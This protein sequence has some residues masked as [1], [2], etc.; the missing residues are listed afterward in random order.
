MRHARFITAAIGLLTLFFCPLN[1]AKSQEGPPPPAP[2]PEAPLVVDETGMVSMNFENLDVR[3]L[4]KYIS[5]LTGKNFIVDESVRGPITIVSPTKIPI[6]EAYKVF[7]SILEVKGFAAIPAGKVMKVAAKG[8]QATRNIDLKVGGDLSQIVPEDTLVTQLIPLQYVS[9]EK[10]NTALARLFSRE[11]AVIPYPTTNTL[12][13]TDYSSNIHRLVKIIKELDVP[14]YETRITVVPL[15]Y[16]AADSLATELSQVIEQA[17]VLPGGPP[18]PA[19]RGRPQTQTSEK[20]IKIIPDERTNSVIILANDDDTRKVLDLIKR[21]DVETERT[22]IHVYFLKNSNAEEMGKVMNN[23]VSK[24]KPK[25][26]EAVPLISEDK[27]TNALLIDATPEDYASLEKIIQK[28]DVLRNQVLVE[29]LIAEVGYDKTFELGVEWRSL[30]GFPDTA[31]M[32]AGR[33]NAEGFGEMLFG[34]G[35][36]NY[37]TAG[38]NP[39]SGLTGV[40]LG[41]VQKMAGAGTSIPDFGILV[42]ALQTAQGVNIL[43]TPQILTTDNQEATIKVVKNIPYVTKF[44]TGTGDQNPVQN[45]EY[46]DVGITLKIT[47]HVSK[48]GVVRMEVDTEISDVTGKQVSGLYSTPETY[49]RATKT[50][51]IVGD[52]HTIVLGGLVRDDKS[53]TEDKVPI[54]GDIPLL[55]LLFRTTSTVSKKTN[56][57]IFITPRVVHTTQQIA[58]LTKLKRHEMSD[59]DQRMSEEEEEKAVGEYEMRE[60]EHAEIRDLKARYGS[61]VPA[62]SP[63]AAVEPGPES[64]AP[65]AAREDAEGSSASAPAATIT[66]AP[67]SDPAIATS[68]ASPVVAASP[69]SP[70]AAPA[71]SPPEAKKESSL[72]DMLPRV[73]FQK[74]DKD[75]ADKRKAAQRFHQ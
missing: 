48:E 44:E 57:L 63:A 71:S 53:D 12:I 23:I 21:L 61:T 50:S 26:E 49:V 60:Q 27:A 75:E 66:P 30:E 52:N 18:V 55:G 54:L 29:V 28:L 19:R 41:F 42:H 6:D 34:E 5:D 36:M 11:A 39:T 72:L 33:S 14:G 10:I 3:V 62:P 9:V 65:V 16:A 69:A 51:V 68:L 70:A 43:S 45:I 40:S 47:P 35:L 32:K 4:I 37:S 20:L 17:G 24:R 8:Q 13:V 1:P 67:V 38:T 22:R 74:K 15:R 73:S 56:L 46:K 58:D 31:T 59:I 7:E 64:P 25:G 2:S